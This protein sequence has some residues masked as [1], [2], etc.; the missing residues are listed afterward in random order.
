MAGTIQ[1][2]IL[3]GETFKIRIPAGGIKRSAQI[4]DGENAGRVVGTGQMKRDII[5]TFYN[6]SMQVDTSDLDQD[7]YSRF[8]DYISAPVD[9]HVAAF[10]YNQRT[11]TGEFYVT[12][13]EDVLDRIDEHGNH[14]SGLAVN[15]IAMGPARTP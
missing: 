7:A 2:F 15:F 6:Y 10:P 4:L 13:I 12:S 9:S 5:G 1:P 11:I 3:D 8:Y 14:W